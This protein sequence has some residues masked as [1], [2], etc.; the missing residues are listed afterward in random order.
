MT[1]LDTYGARML[2]Q[3]WVEFTATLVLATEEAR[4][5]FACQH[6]DSIRT[7]TKQLEEHQK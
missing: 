7:V 2:A 1:D 4:H 5:K 6:S 3:K